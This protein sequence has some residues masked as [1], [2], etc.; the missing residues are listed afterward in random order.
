M[1]IEKVKIADIVPYKNNAKKHPQEQIDQIIAS[2]EECG[3]NDPIAIDENNVIIEGHGRWMALQQM[4]ADEV[5][6][7]RLTH[8]SEEQKKAYILIHNKL[9]M[10][11]GFDE[12]ILKLELQDI[13]SIDMEQFDFHFDFEDEQFEDI[14][15]LG[16]GSVKGFEHELKLD[17]IRIVL[18]EE[19][20]EK[21]ME[22]YNEYCDINGVNFG[23]IGE[24][25]K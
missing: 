6:C 19:E 12:A 25:L 9:T 16:N 15:D 4:G 13:V 1:Q 20:Y 11:T 18:T 24:L 8:L 5:E 23:F 22:R 10:N 21:F 7:I 14:D 17:S 2:I 3:F